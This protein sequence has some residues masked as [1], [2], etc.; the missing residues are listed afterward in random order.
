MTTPR[1][2]P[3]RV[4]PSALADAND[5]ADRTAAALHRRTVERDTARAERDSARASADHWRACAE[6]LELECERLR[7]L[8]GVG[9]D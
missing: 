9:C 1:P 6:E 4:A 3:L 7:T 2:A 8:V 5:R